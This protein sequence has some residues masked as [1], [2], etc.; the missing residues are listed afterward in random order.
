MTGYIISAWLARHLVWGSMVVGAPSYCPD[1]TDGGPLGRTCDRADCT[2]V[3]ARC[4]VTR[5]W[6]GP[7]DGYWVRL[8]RT[9]TEDK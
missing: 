5:V 9:T 4:T 6:G 7:R 3:P 2:G 8:E 1:Q